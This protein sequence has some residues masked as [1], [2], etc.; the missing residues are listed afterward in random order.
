M[1]AAPAWQSA[2]RNPRSAMSLVPVRRVRWRWLVVVVVLVGF[3]RMV[4][5]AGLAVLDFRFHLDHRHARRMV[6][7]HLPAQHAHPHQNREREERN[8]AR[9]EE[10][11]VGKECRTE[12]A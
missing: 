6:E 4:M 1:L 5:V 10:R 3:A 11:R 9:S 8:H 12:G 7:D 2:I